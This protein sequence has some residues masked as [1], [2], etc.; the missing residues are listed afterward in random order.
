MQ[1]KLYYSRQ[2]NS[3]N[4]VGKTQ[5]NKQFDKGQKITQQTGTSE[6]EAKD[7]VQMQNS[8][9]EPEFQEH[10]QKVWCTL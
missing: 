7:K 8:E 6:A 3:P 1:R 5:R 2:V 4:H 10:I 9:Q